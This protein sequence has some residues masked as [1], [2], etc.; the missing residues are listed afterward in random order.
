VQISV[1]VGQN[2]LLALA[3]IEAGDFFGEMAVLD[4]GPRSATATAAVDTSAYYLSRDEFLR[5]LEQRP[6][7]ALKFFRGFSGR[8]RTSNEKLQQAERL[9]MVGRFARTIVHDFKNPLAVIGLAAEVV[10]AET[11]PLAIRQKASARIAQQADRMTS[12]LTE[13]LEFTKPSGQHL[14]FAALCYPQ[15]VGH[16]AEELRPELTEKRVKLEFSCPPPDVVVR[17]DQQRLSRVFFNLVNNAVDEM[18]DGGTITFR[19]TL[20]ADEVTTEVTDTG[21]GIAPEIAARLFEP[22]ATFGKQQGTGLGL[23]ICKKI[24][25]DH[26]G[27][28]WARSEPGA[29]ATFGFSLPVA[30]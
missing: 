5:L 16:V 7:L 4:E 6:G 17:L 13:L 20:A 10:G 27:R 9:S 22:F 14:T 12:M 23:S 15:F 19:F 8:I 2:E 28:I 1:G 11:T 21:K 26:G 25:G 24:V 29:G 18:P 30:K 3:T